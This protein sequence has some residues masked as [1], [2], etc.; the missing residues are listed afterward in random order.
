MNRCFENSSGVYVR[1]NC[2][3]TGCVVDF[4]DVQIYAEMAKLQN[5]IFATVVRRMAGWCA[6]DCDF[7]PNSAWISDGMVCGD[8]SLKMW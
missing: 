6:N 2:C 7:F 8:V 3:I 4:F 5:N 1:L